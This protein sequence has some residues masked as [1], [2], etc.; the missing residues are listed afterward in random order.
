MDVRARAP[1]AAGVNPLYRERPTSFPPSASF[2]NGSS[3]RRRADNARKATCRL[4]CSVHIANTPPSCGSPLRARLTGAASAP[5]SSPCKSP[6]AAVGPARRGGP[7]PKNSAT[8]PSPFHGEWPGC[9]GSFSSNGT[10]I[11]IERRDRRFRGRTVQALESG[12]WTGRIRRAGSSDLDG[13]VSSATLVTLTAP[14]RKEGSQSS[15]C[16]FSRSRMSEPVSLRRG[17]HRCHG[18]Q[19]SSR[20]APV[21]RQQGPLHPSLLSAATHGNVMRLLA[22]PWACR[23]VSLFCASMP[24]QSPVRPRQRPRQDGEATQNGVS[25][26]RR[27]PSPRKGYSLSHQP[28]AQLVPRKPRFRC[29]QGRK[30]RL[31]PPLT[32]SPCGRGS[33]QVRR[34]PCPPASSLRRSVV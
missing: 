15:A 6:M 33:D 30:S 10:Q 12:R 3:S 24:V 22:S 25:G 8:P 20:L 9:R 4:T 34:L 11:G 14:P 13:C 26:E 2:G 27:G 28:A 32:P 7:T 1:S 16:R 5:G 18:R 17:A 19:S 21:T 31:N 23:P 29:R